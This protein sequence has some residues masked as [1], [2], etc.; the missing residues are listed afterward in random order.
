MLTA[1]TLEGGG[2][3]IRFNK[4]GE[5][6]SS[7]SLVLSILLTTTAAIAIA[8]RANSKERVASW[9]ATSVSKPKVPGLRPAVNYSQRWAEIT[10]LMS[11]CPWSEWKW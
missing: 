2:V 4:T 10:R 6:F 11:K 5:I 3:V 9:L 7:V 8:K 1:W